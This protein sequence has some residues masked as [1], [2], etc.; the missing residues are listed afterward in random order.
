MER[1][2]K[3]SISEEVAQ[4]LVI[5][6]AALMLGKELKDK[7]RRWSQ[8]VVKREPLK[9]FD[10]NGQ[11]LFHE[12][13]VVSGKSVI[14][15]IKASANKVLGSVVWTIEVGPRLWHPD[16]AISIV[17]EMFEKEF[18]E[19]PDD[20][21][22]VCYSYPK[23]G[24]LAS[25]KVEKRP[26]KYLLIDA[27]TYQ[28]I[29]VELKEDKGFI[30]SGVWSVYN[31]ISEKDKLDHVEKWERE[32]SF[33]ERFTD[34]FEVSD[35]LYH[36]YEILVEVLE[37]LY[38]VVGYKRLDMTLYGQ[39]HCVWCADAMG[40]MILKYHNYYYEQPD[41]VNAMNTVWDPNNCD[42][43][44]SYA[45]MCNGIENLTRNYLK[46]TTHT[47]SH[48]DACNEIDHNRPFGATIKGHARTCDGYK[49]LYFFIDPFISDHKRYLHILDPWP[50]NSNNNFC[51]PAG[52][53]EYWEDFEAPVRVYW[54]WVYYRPCT[55]TMTCEE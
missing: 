43:G 39:E 2:E 45:G 42:D 14:G 1:K 17:S 16:K 11:L 5:A 40:Q 52:G 25:K 4:K 20:V 41:I 55:G 38:K 47:P 51:N 12:F 3:N 9:I 48:S 44:T 36:V 37:Q 24:A 26:H 31:S 46:A 54:P 34:T 22:L 15:R 32:A 6:N 33:L 35:T 49:I 30:G 18:R 23:I 27:A 28:R 50:P 29:T 7:R 19:K 13:D 21:K 8:A 53:T 10:M